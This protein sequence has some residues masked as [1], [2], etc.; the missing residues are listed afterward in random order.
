MKIARTAPTSSTGKR[1][2]PRSPM[3]VR[4]PWSLPSLVVPGT[5]G[6]HGG[7]TAGGTHLPPTGPLPKGSPPGPTM[8]TASGCGTTTTS[9]VLPVKTGTHGG[10][11][12]RGTPLHRPAHC[13]RDP[14]PEPTGQGPHTRTPTQHVILGRSE[15]PPGHHPTTPVP[16]GPR[17][18]QPPYVVPDSDPVPMGAGP[19]VKCW[20]DQP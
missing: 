8:G 18:R 17:I 3:R 7:V 12:V 4:H 14:H 13:Q 9:L 11:T 5:P 1:T 2:S 16:I 10:V 19:T 6:N 15:E 20:Y